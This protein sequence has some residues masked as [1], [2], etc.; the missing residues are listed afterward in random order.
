MHSSLF[1]SFFFFNDTATTEIYPLSLHD[2]LPI[3]LSLA[4]HDDAH[5]IVGLGARL[6]GRVR[7]I[8]HGQRLHELGI[9]PAVHA[10]TARAVLRVDHGGAHPPA[11]RPHPPPPAAQPPRH[12]RTPRT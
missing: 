8:T 11:Q 12:P 2:A 7:K 1:F 6:E 9:A 4:R 5:E 10:V 3:H